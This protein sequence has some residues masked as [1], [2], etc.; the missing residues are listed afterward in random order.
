LSP[1]TVAGLYGQKK[2]MFREQR[3]TVTEHR[4]RIVASGWIWSFYA[5][6]M[7]S[8]GFGT[9]IAPDGKLVDFE[10]HDPPWGGSIGGGGVGR[11]HVYVGL[12]P[13]SRSYLD[14]HLGVSR[15][16][17][18]SDKA[19]RDPA[20]EFSSHFDYHSL[21]K[22]ASFYRG[23]ASSTSMTAADFPD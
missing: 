16:P 19:P 14:Q 15:V 8:G 17:I 1:I 10:L 13:T 23:D 18:M 20:K 3:P 6:D 22:L 2:G 21:R 12:K 7:T 5:S 9:A 4:V 11:R